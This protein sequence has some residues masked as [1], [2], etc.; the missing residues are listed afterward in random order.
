MAPGT[1]PWVFPYVREPRAPSSPFADRDLLRPAVPL[2]F[3]GP[4]G[5][6]TVLSLVDSGSDHVF[7]APWVAQAIGVDLHQALEGEVL[8]GGA[9]RRPRFVETRLV[10]PPPDGV[11]GEPVEWQAQVGFFDAWEPAWP[12]VVGQVGF[13]DRFTVTMSRVA[14]LLAIEDWDEFDIRFGVPAATPPDNPPRFRP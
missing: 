8:I 10:L 7:A 5:E 1:F 6:Q 13:F 14:T 2:R 4:L 12:A 3:V 11:E 9:P